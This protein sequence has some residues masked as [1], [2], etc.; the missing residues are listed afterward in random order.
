[1]GHKRL[2][3]KLRVITFRL[4]ELHGGKQWDGIKARSQR[5]SARK[6]DVPSPNNIIQ[7]AINP[8]RTPIWTYTVGIP[9]SPS[10]AS[11]LKQNPLLRLRSRNI[12]LEFAFPLLPSFYVSSR[13][14]IHVC[15]TL[16]YVCVHVQPAQHSIAQ[17]SAAQRTCNLQMPWVQ[18]VYGSEHMIRFYVSPSPSEPLAHS[19]SSALSFSFDR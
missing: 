13:K 14:H 10:T 11:I 5:I 15:A 17:P 9:S 8:S 6:C 4:Y 7:Y 19:H 2:A 18:L 3:K 12:L 16:S 1:M